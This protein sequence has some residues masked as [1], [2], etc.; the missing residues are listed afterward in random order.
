MTKTPLL[1]LVSIAGLLLGAGCGNIT[2]TLGGDPN[3]VM[4]GT[5]NY[6]G[7]LTLPA[8][9]ELV[10]R[11]MDPTGIP[12]TPNPTNK[13]LPVLAQAKVQ[14][15]PVQLAEQTIKV[16]GP[17]PISFRLEYTASDDML[18]HGLTL[19]ARISF[20]GRVRLRTVN[21]RAVTL[22]NANDPHAVRVEAVAR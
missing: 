4:T 5:V 21:R 10:I 9:A 15:S 1:L 13:D 22:G 8:D 17:G 2:T 19:E 6:N 3:R 14:P 20:G 16:T 7:D 18:R 12:Q 11:L